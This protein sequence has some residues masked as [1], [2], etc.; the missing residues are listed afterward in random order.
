MPHTLEVACIARWGWLGCSERY[1]WLQVAMRWTYHFTF[2]WWCLL[3]D[4]RIRRKR[5]CRG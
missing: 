4:Q 2:L 5:E 1:Y 3:M